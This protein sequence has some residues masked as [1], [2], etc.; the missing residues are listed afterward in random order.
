M[1]T[2]LAHVNEGK[3]FKTILSVETLNAKNVREARKLFDAYKDRGIIKNCSFEDSIIEFCDGYANVGMNFSLPE[4][5][6]T[7]FYKP[8]FGLSLCEIETYL[9]SFIILLIG[10]NVLYSIREVAN[11][12]KKL[13]SVDTTEI[14]RLKLQRT[15]ALL[16]FIEIL[17]AINSERKEMLLSSLETKAEYELLK[18]PNNRRSLAQFKSYFK[19]DEIIEGFW[20]SDLPKNI[21]LFYYPLYLWWKITGIIPLRPRE[22]LLTPRS[23]IKEVNGKYYIDLRRNKLKG[24]GGVVHY[25]INDDYQIK[26]YQINETLYNTIKAYQ[27]DTDNGMDNETHTLF[28]TEPHYAMFNHKCPY[29]S[30]FYTYVNLCCC[31]RLFYFHIVQTQKEIKIV[32]IDSN[33][34]CTLSDNE[35]E[36][37]HLGDTRHIAMINIICEGGSPTMAMEL[38]GHVDISMSSHYFSNISTLIE[39]KTNSVYKKFIG[40]AEQMIFGENYFSP[41]ISEEIY[42]NLEDGARCYSPR[43]Y[44]GDISDCLQ[45]SGDYAE[46]GYCQRCTYYRKNGLEFFVEIEDRFKSQI[47]K[48]SI[49][50]RVMLNK[51]R[52]G[53]GYEEDIK[54]A[55]LRIQA[56]S[57]TYQDYLFQKLL[58]NKEQ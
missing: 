46:I 20:K 6:Y 28:R 4:I 39:C 41:T 51:F 47:E 27:Q 19:F 10:K 37:I 30:R 22:F 57:T 9:K 40:N 42:V 24:S 49:Y 44:D 16:D 56:S 35:I 25:N 26:T 58:H 21:R 54:E 32:D 52:I 15:L 14:M 11:D 53:L 43:F 45:A 38:A 2:N 1:E 50:L 48:D 13:F 36:M 18:N 29:T 8:I 7:K 23:C 17:P 33:T 34:A 55:V 12:A 31:L 3:L 5:T